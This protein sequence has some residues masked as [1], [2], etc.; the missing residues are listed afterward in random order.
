MGRHTFENLEGWKDFPEK[1]KK[2][3]IVVAGKNFGCG[4]SRQQAVDCFKSLGVSVIIAES[5]GSIYERNAVNSGMPIITLDNA[6]S[7]IKN[8]DEIK[9]DFSAGTVEN[10]SKNERQKS[11]PFSE[12]QMKL[13]Q[14]GGL[15]KR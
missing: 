9:V 8:G 5:F 6:V 12:I 3:D 2:G 14:R 13:Y 15:L 11:S 7:F 1:M 10:C 4:S